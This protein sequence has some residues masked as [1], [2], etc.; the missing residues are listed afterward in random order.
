MGW[1]RYICLRNCDVIQL[2]PQ[3]MIMGN[4]EVLLASSRGTTKNPS[5]RCSYVYMHRNSINSRWFR[6]RRRRRLLCPLS[7]VC[8]VKQRGKRPL[9]S[10]ICVSALRRPKLLLDCLNGFQMV[11]T[12]SI[13][14]PCVCVHMIKFWR[15]P[16]KFLCHVV[17][18]VKWRDLVF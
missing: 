7:D 16:R 4:E 2:W 14:C 8:W 1:W 18:T 10:L 9:A 6:Q 15:I 11:V 5:R 13:L 12:H 17:C 3:Q